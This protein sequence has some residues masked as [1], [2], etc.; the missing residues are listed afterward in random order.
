MKD[1]LIIHAGAGTW[2]HI[3]IDDVVNVIE[4]SLKAGIEALK[5]GGALEG[6]VAATKALEDSGILNAG[7]G[8]VVDITGKVSMDAGVMDGGSGRAGAVASVTYPKNPVI[9]ARKVMEL[10]DHILLAGPD[11][12]KFAIKLGLEK[13][14]GPSEKAMKRYRDILSRGEEGVPYRKSFKLALELGL[15]DTVGAVAVDSSGR[16]A[17]AVSTGGVIMKFPGRVGDSSIP[18]AGFY[19]SQTG[20]AVATGIGETII[21][22]FLTLR[23]V[24]LMGEGYS[25]ETSAKLAIMKHTSISG[26]NTAGLIVVRYDGDF[27]AAFNTEAMPWGF[28]TSE[29]E[30]G[31]MGL[32]KRKL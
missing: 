2:R 27:S 26:P 19:A 5:P 7:V 20:A 30:M 11:A 4:K 13:H 22:S 15:H 24:E 32:P 31:V 28:I 10:T 3:N 9:L 29:G 18:G 23:A 8:S 14:P 17:A 21:R 12:D 6:A 1:V 25:A 16:V